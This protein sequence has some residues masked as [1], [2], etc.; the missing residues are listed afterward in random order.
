MY[1]FNNL[2]A[3]LQKIEGFDVYVLNLLYICN[4]N[5]ANMYNRLQ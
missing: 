4:V 1:R 2:V 3:N 5:H